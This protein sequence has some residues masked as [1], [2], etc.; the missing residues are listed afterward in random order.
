MELSC[1]RSQLYS[2]YNT[3]T[4]ANSQLSCVNK[5][6]DGRTSVKWVGWSHEGKREGK[7]QVHASCDEPT[8][9]DIVRRYRFICVHTSSYAHLPFCAYLCACDIHQCDRGKLANC[10]LP[11]HEACAHPCS[12]SCSKMGSRMTRRH[13]HVTQ[14]YL[15]LCVHTQNTPKWPDNIAYSGLVTRRVR[16]QFTPFA[17]QSGFG[18]ACNIKVCA[19]ASDLI[20]RKQVLLSNSWPS[21]LPSWHQPLL[22]AFP[23]AFHRSWRR[24][25]VLVRILQHEKFANLQPWERCKSSKVENGYMF[26]TIPCFK[27]ETIRSHTGGFKLT[28][29]KTGSAKRPLYSHF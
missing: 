12:C 16:L 19:L 4:V 13:L 14:R 28:K 15:N 6:R 24:E 8:K 20:W 7:L 29:T 21:R 25:N 18:R 11:F 1:I 17:T 22:P 2:I 5:Q 9:S 26:T 10:D 23:L 27:T 3:L